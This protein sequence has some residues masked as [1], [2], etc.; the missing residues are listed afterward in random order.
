MSREVKVINSGSH[1]YLLEGNK[2]EIYN[3]MNTIDDSI[4]ILSHKQL[5][6]S[7]TVPDFKRLVK[8]KVDLQKELSE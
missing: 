3:A 6:V 2:K 1:H 8:R 4:V 5:Q 7:F